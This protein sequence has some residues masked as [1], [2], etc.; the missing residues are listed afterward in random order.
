MSTQ[1]PLITGITGITGKD[2]GSNLAASSAG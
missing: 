2:D 1:R